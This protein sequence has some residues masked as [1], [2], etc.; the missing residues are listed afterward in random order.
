[1][2]NKLSQFSLLLRRP[3]VLAPSLAHEP[4]VESDGARLMSQLHD[5]NVL[6]C[7]F[8]FGISPLALNYP[9]VESTWAA[10]VRLVER[11]KK[12]MYALSVRLGRGTRRCTFGKYTGAARAQ[13]A[14]L[15]SL[16]VIASAS[17]ALAYLSRIVHLDL[18]FRYRRVF[19][20]RYRG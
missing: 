9:R 8:Y 20:Q 6:S 16:G 1:M 11:E 12:M 4:I 19:Q 18:R 10:R 14:V 5:D 7:C 17:F 15:R 13:T 3:L 2:N